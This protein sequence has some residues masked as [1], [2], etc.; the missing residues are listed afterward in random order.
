MRRSDPVLSCERFP[1]DPWDGAQGTLEVHA[2]D[3]WLSCPILARSPIAHLVG[4]EL[5][6]GVGNR[7]LLYDA[8]GGLAR[9]EPSEPK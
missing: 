6:G 4:E 7:R 3:R 8:D 1:S 2:A 9:V 5:V